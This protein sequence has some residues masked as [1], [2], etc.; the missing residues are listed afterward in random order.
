MKTFVFS[1]ECVVA[2]TGKIDVPD[3]F[4]EK[5]AELYAKT[6]I[7]KIFREEMDCILGH[8]KIIEN[9]G[10]FSYDE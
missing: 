5:K 8:D 4:D 10:Y 2:Y 3:S 6:H 7:D 1:A 9:S